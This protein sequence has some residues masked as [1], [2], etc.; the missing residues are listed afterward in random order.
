MPNPFQSIEE[1]FLGVLQGHLPP[2]TIAELLA[3]QDQILENQAA[4]RGAL[5][6]IIDNQKTAQADLLA[7][8][9]FLGMGAPPLVT[10]AQLNQLG[11]QLTQETAAVEQFDGSMQAPIKAA[12]VPVTE[13]PPQSKT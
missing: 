10:Q 4:I 12:S 11:K 6:I 8:K 3:N 1:L 13:A 5:S 7:I 2:A 9:T